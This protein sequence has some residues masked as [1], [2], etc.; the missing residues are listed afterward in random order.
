M[1]PGWKGV[2]REAWVLPTSLGFSPASLYETTAMCAR[3][4]SCNT[5]S[6]KPCLT[7]SCKFR[8]SFLNQVILTPSTPGAPGRLGQGRS[9]KFFHG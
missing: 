4:S 8:A 1:G 6:E 3:P 5:S 9:P 2:K 7:L